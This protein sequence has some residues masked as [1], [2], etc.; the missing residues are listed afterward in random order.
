MRG[1]EI[2][3]ANLFIG[4]V[5]EVMLLPDWLALLFD[6][7]D[8]PARWLC[9]NWSSPHGWLHIVSDFLV[10]GAYVA[11]PAVLAFF[12]RKRPDLPFPRI[13]WLFCA[14]ILSCGMTH[15]VEAV[16]FWHPI[17]RVSGALKLLT[18]AASWA[19]V[20]SLILV[21]PRLLHLPGLA[22][23]Y[24]KLER[25]M[26]ARE[27]AEHALRQHNRDLEMLMYVI[28]H[29]LREPLR[30]IRGFSEI[31]EKR[32]AAGLGEG[33]TMMVGRI[34]K[35]AERLDAL[36]QDVLVLLQARQME[37]ARERIPAEEI[38]REV[39][40]RLE[41]S[42]RQRDASI[43]VRGDLP[44]F[45]VNRTWVTQAVYNLVA[46]ALKFHAPGAPP[47]V[48][49]EPYRGGEAGALVGIVVADRGP[50]VEDAQKER[51]FELFKRGVDRSVEGTGAG[52]AIAK[53]VAERHGGRC[54]VED[55]PGGGARFILA[56]PRPEE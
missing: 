29:D 31:L 8:F 44:L 12:V 4:P 11:I 25:E 56:F 24:N 46:N 34:N 38:A 35:A 16:I 42:V 15:L 53:E 9:G 47:E 49:I 45:Y 17:Y 32:H 6:T 39:M 2:C 50:G 7:R 13:F 10:F 3:Y 36:V 21:I 52:L 1:A 41:D 33:G 48:T 18:A 19:T 20:F 51:I 54:W 28:S 30:G 23:A 40:L 55:R 26:A 43:T 14:F 37:V 5:P 27:T 22:A